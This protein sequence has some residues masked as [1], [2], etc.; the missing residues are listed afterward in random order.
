MIRPSWQRCDQGEPFR[1]LG[2]WRCSDPPLCDSGDWTNTRRY[3]T[4]TSRGCDSH[5]SPPLPLV[6]C[7]VVATVCT[8][9]SPI[10]QENNV[11]RSWNKLVYCTRSN[12]DLVWNCL[13]QAGVLYVVC[14]LWFRV[15]SL[16]GVS[17]TI[18]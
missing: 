14:G 8:V 11:V 6:P 3:V 1:C 5:L 16:V 4:T 10:Q 15:D 18:T 2:D 17:L 13:D 7:D 9:V 12:F